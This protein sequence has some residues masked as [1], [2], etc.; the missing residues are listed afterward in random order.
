LL[1]VASAVNMYVARYA[2]PTLGFLL[3][4]AA[5]GLT[6]LAP[7]I[8]PRAGRAGAADEAAAIPLGS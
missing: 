4:A 2:L 5:L 8:I 7:R 3:P 1:V 6:A